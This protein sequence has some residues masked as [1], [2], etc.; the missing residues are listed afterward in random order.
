MPEH[1]TR[2]TLTAS[3]WCAK[4]GRLTEHRIDGGRRGPCLECPPKPIKAKPAPIAQK[5]LFEP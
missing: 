1:F 5:G 2:N 4:C 3:V